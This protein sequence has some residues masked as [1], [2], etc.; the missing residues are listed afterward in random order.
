MFVD[1][2]GSAGESHPLTCDFYGPPDSLQS[3]LGDF[4]P[5]DA[6]RR[7]RDQLARTSDLTQY[8]TSIAMDDLDD[9]RAA[10]GYEKIN[11]VGGSYGTRAALV[12]ARQHPS[13]VRTLTLQGIV[14]P[15][16]LMPQHFARDAQ[17]SLDGVL[18]DCEQD[19]QCHA[20]FPALRADVTKVFERLRSGPVPVTVTDSRT[21]ARRTVQLPY[22]MV[23]ETVR[24]M[25]YVSAGASYIPVGDA[26]SGE[27][28]LHLAGGAVTRCPRRVQ[29]KDR[30]RSTV[31]TSPSP[32]PKISLGSTPT[33]P[34]SRR[35]A[36][37][38]VITV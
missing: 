30:V 18:G 33:A 13:S 34:P 21:H 29:R 31:C 26:R 15:T 1:Q 28:Q 36:P 7:C 24:Y 3:Y 6:V 16:V 10:L 25:L 27:R 23:A 2:R 4:L 8:T 11:L 19:A 12:F 38:S 22:D 35:A 17:R 20:A 37:F 9:V 5:P 14:P 32:A